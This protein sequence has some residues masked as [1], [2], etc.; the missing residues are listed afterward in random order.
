MTRN[1]I[2][3]GL[4]NRATHIKFLLTYLL[5]I[6]YGRRLFTGLWEG[7]SSWSGPLQIDVGGFH[8]PLSLWPGD[9]P[10][11]NKD[12]PKPYFATVYTPQ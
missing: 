5:W 9:Q 1:E 11:V 10:E 6:F 4:F 2:V 8:L 7:W 12:Y 3:E